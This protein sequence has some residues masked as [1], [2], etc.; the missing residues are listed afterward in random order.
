[1]VLIHLQNVDYPQQKKYYAQ[2][3]VKVSFQIVKN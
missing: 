1:M 3:D 2:L